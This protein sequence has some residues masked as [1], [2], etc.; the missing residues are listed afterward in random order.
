MSSSTSDLRSAEGRRSH[1]TPRNPSTR[2]S[3]MGGSR[4]GDASSTGGSTCS[5]L[6]PIYHLSFESDIE[7]HSF[8]E[9]I[10][11]KET[12]ATNPCNR[13]RSG[14]TAIEQSLADLKLS[15]WETWLLGKE[16]QGRIDLQNKLSQELKQEEDRRIQEQ[17]KEQKKHF[18]EEQHKEWVRRKQ[19]QERK[20]KEQKLQKEKQEKELEEWQRHVIE[21]K[22]KERYQEWLRKKN[23]EE[24]K[25][26]RRQKDE[27]DK[28]FTVQK[29][30]KEK[31]EQMFKEWLEQAKNKSRPTLNSYGFVNGKLTGYYD[32][33]SYPAPG[34]YNPVPWKPIPMP[35]P[36][37]ETVKPSSGKKKK[38]PISHQLYR[39][40]NHIVLKPK[41]NLQVGGGMVRR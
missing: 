31:S 11:T 7:D 30:K 41:D 27:E 35:P 14:T 13:S 36:P 5:L 28:H 2:E 37:K 40:S 1:S 4:S 16:K 15:P 9:E 10:L 23:E 6:S 21:E 25:R 39:S 38:R 12:E 22:S 24:Q 8:H 18:A 26:K 20:E 17:K 19:E 29:E 33:S 3:V 32:G 34:F